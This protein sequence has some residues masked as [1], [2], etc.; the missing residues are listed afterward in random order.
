MRITTHTHL[1]LLGFGDH[2]HVIEQE[3]VSVLGLHPGLQLSV[4]VEKERPI[5]AA[6]VGLDQ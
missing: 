4:S 6:E 2:Q 1:C 5:G 3:E